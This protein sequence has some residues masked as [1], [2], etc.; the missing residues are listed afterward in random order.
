MSFANLELLISLEI[1]IVLYGTMQLYCGELGQEKK[2][3]LKDLIFGPMLWKV[4]LQVTRD[5]M[6]V[7]FSAISSLFFKKKNSF[8][9]FFF[10]KFT[11]NK[12]TMKKCLE[13]NG[14]K[15]EMGQIERSAGD[16][17]RLHAEQTL[18]G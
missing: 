6:R 9:F 12:K 7:K 14:D 2:G 16:L 18:D 8:F 5:L 4:I 11:A 3:R 13:E 1:Q 10:L 15:D 17:L